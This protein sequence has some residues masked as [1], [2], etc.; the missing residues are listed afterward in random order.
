MLIN[1]TDCIARL[2]KK[3]QV[4]VVLTKK[5]NFE[6][7]AFKDYSC[8]SFSILLPIY[9]QS[10]I[11][12]L[13]YYLWTSSNFL[14]FIKKLRS[15]IITLSWLTFNSYQSQN[16]SLT[17]SISERRKIRTSDCLRVH[18]V[19]SEKWCKRMSWIMENSKRGRENCYVSFHGLQNGTKAGDGSKYLRCF[20]NIITIIEVPVQ[21]RYERGKLFF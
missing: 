17:S 6:K 16:G 21:P 10:C 4:V 18:R 7:I 19:L 14:S 2:L 1:V 3:Y 8:F 9:N 11:C 13:L 20:L 5:N 12:F 15:T